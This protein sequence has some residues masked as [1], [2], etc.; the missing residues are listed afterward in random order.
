MSRPATPTPMDSQAEATPATPGNELDDFEYLPQAQPRDESVSATAMPATTVPALRSLRQHA[1]V[2]LERGPPTSL[3][4]PEE[5]PEFDLAMDALPEP[6]PARVSPKRRRDSDEQESIASDDDDDDSV[7]PEVLPLRTPQQVRAPVVAPGAPLR[8]QRPRTAAATAAVTSAPMLSSFDDLVEDEST[9]EDMVAAY[10]DDADQ[11]AT[12]TDLYMSEEEARVR[13]R[14]QLRTILRSHPTVIVPHERRYTTVFMLYKSMVAAACRAVNWEGVPGGKNG[15]AAFTSAL[16]RDVSA[17]DKVLWSQLMPHYEVPR[18]RRARQ[19]GSASSASASPSA[20]MASLTV[21]TP[22]PAARA[23]PVSAVSRTATAPVRRTPAAA[24][25]SRTAPV[26]PE[27]AGVFATP[28]TTVVHLQQRSQT[29]RERLAFLRFTAG[30]AA[31]TASVDDVLRRIEDSDNEME[32]L[33][34]L[35]AQERAVALVA[36]AIMYPGASDEAIARDAQTVLMRSM[37]R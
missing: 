18:I 37:Q 27:P 3:L 14:R 12:A 9:E 22:V 1:Q 21:V 26:R 35:S 11:H 5:E 13:V 10:D 25:V 6:V 33:R 8:R 7:A 31:N 15:L 4:L 20:A 29:V 30:T 34:N 2:F 24:P 17:E 19:P 32:T 28:P 16:W 23:A 36:Y